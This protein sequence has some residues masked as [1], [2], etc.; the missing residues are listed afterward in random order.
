MVKN[1]Y[2]YSSLPI[3]VPLSSKIKWKL[4]EHF[5]TLKAR[6]LKGQTTLFIYKVLKVFKIILK[7][8]KRDDRIKARKEPPI[9]ARSAKGAPYQSAKREGSPLSKSEARKEP[10]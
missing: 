8:T 1:I 9:K 3:E 2:K 7:R 10:L 5:G 4:K 6:K